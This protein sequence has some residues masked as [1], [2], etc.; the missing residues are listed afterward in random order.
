MPK[1]QLE[2]QR[3]ELRQLAPA[4]L[5][6]R[7]WKR[8]R[9]RRQNLQNRAQLG[10]TLPRGAT[11]QRPASFASTSAGARAGASLPAAGDNAADAMMEATPSPTTPRADPMHAAPPGSPSAVEARAFFGSFPSGGHGTCEE[12]SHHGGWDRQA[13][14]FENFETIDELVD[15]ASVEAAF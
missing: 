3:P 5:P 1:P 6:R 12:G 8:T 9:G 11:G 10:R 14:V 15:P 4:R 2:K 13:K 7:L